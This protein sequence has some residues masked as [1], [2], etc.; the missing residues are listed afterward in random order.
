[1]SCYKC[2]SEQVTGQEV[3]CPTCS[4]ISPVPA[5]SPSGPFASTVPPPTPGG[6]Y[7]YIPKNAAYTYPDANNL[8]LG[9]YCAA[10]G[11]VTVP[12][13]FRVSMFNANNPRPQMR[14]GPWV[15]GSPVFGQNTDWVNPAGKYKI[16]RPR[17]VD[18]PPVGGRPGFPYP[19]DATGDVK[20][21]IGAPGGNDSVWLDLGHPVLTTPNGRKF[22]PLFAPLVLD[23]DGR[24]NV[25]V[26]GNVRGADG[27]HVSNQGW[28]PWEVGLN[29]V[30]ADAAEYRNL[31]QGVSSAGM[32]ARGLP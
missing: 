5:D 3:C 15:P 14:L 7:P 19:D 24:L 8:F 26:H 1:M 11:E 12:S 30:F 10:T 23:L 16:L 29:R 13:F 2:V 17:P 4:S 9:S 18:H 31:F 27:V 28:G 6:P 20:N 21:L 25:N 32:G 22:K